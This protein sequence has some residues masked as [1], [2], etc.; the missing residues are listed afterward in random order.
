MSER[1]AHKDTSATRHMMVIFSLSFRSAAT[2]AGCEFISAPYCAHRASYLAMLPSEKQ[3]SRWTSHSE[4][5]PL[6]APTCN[7]ASAPV[8]F[9]E[10]YQDCMSSERTVL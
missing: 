10:S 9:E 8:S 6:S 4:D 5:V 1:E 7:R 2:S 3:C